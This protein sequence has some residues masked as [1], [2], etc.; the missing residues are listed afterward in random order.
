MAQIA[1]IHA[2]TGP[3]R[4]PPAPVSGAARKTRGELQDLRYR[5]ALG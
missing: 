4:R 3:L 5:A 1:S 2:V